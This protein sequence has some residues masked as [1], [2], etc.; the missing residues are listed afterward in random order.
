MLWRGYPREAVLLA[1]LAIVGLSPL[2]VANWQDGSRLALT[3]AIALDGTV[4]TDPYQRQF[5]GDV[6]Y[7]DGHYYSDKAPGM[8]FLALPAFEVLRATDVI[9]PREERHGALGPAS[10]PLWIL[11]V[12]TSGLMFVLGAFL[13]GRAAEGLAAGTGAAAATAFALGTFALPLTP[14]MFGHLSGGVPV[15]AALVLASLAAGRHRGVLAAAGFCAALGVVFEYQ[16]ALAAL[17]VAAYVLA[18]TRRARSVG[19]FA[20]GALPPL[21]AL[22]VYNAAAFG[23]PLRFSYRYVES[24]Y[25]DELRTG[26]FGIGIPSPEG[27]WKVLAWPHG[28]V[29]ETPVV[30][31]AAAGL[32][33]LVRGA[34]RAEAVTC[35]AVAAAFLLYDAGFFDPY[36][37]FSPGPRYF[38]P[39]LPFLA[40]GLAPAFRR[41]PRLTGA[42]ALASIGV[43]FV[44]TGTWD[45][46]LDFSTIWM[47]GPIPREAGAVLMGAAALAA[48]AIAAAQ[49][50]RAPRATVD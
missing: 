9:G 35:L 6:A 29:V 23:S 7:R 14:I 37:G 24:R 25:T 16:V 49:L 13:V 1:C 5:S 20:L 48:V 30:V 46:S 38:V 47:R 42:A 40:L 34:Y 32:V 21:L 10:V 44:V 33:A 36:G 17:A 8:S 31:L 26:F 50:R 18:R 28:L 41:W 11:R 27:L 45:R 39:A 12:A 15:F 4:R 19:V 22:G 2:Y 43:M 3:H